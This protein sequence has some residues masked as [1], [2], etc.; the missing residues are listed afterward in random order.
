VVEQQKTS[1]VLFEVNHSAAFGG[2]TAAASRLTQPRV[3]MGCVAPRRARCVGR[4]AAAV[5][6]LEQDSARL[7]LLNHEDSIR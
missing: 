6:H 4:A 3:A 7:L 1:G 5:L 2:D